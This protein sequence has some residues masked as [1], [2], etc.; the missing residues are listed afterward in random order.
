M[1]ESYNSASEIF[2]EE[3]DLSKLEN[4]NRKDLSYKLLKATIFNDRSKVKLLKIA[5]CDSKRMESYIEAVEY[6]KG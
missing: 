1:I 4:Y 2:L 3:L 5:N 6:Y